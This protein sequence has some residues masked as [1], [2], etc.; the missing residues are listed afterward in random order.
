MTLIWY[1]GQYIWT[2]IK[3]KTDGELLK[4][5]NSKIENTATDLSIGT[6]MPE[7]TV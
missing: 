5:I 6:D 4:A 7:Q 3:N 1:G 2:I